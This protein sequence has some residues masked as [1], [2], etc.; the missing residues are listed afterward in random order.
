MNSKT[1]HQLG[2]WLQQ[3]P[4]VTME[5]MTGKHEHG[6]RRFRYAGIVLTYYQQTGAVLLQGLGM[7][8]G[9]KF[10]KLNCKTCQGKPKLIQALNY[11]YRQGGKRMADKH[12]KQPANRVDYHRQLDKRLRER[13]V[14]RG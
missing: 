7:G 1:A 2:E 5:R 11:M 3:H 13:R 6:C 10:E 12:G 8:C 9:V 4:E 14:E